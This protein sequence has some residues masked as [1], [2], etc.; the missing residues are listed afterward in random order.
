M[1]ATSKRTCPHPEKA[2]LRSPAHARQTAAFA[3]RADNARRLIAPPL[4]WY[5]C[6]CSRIHL[7]SREPREEPDGRTTGVAHAVSAALQQWAFP[8]VAAGYAA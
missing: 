2:R 5:R 1:S 7:T 3:V 6:T 4:W 8:P